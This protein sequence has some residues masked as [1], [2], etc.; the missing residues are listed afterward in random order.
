MR[1]RYG[2]RL[3]IG[4]AQDG[5]TLLH[6]SG[7]LRSRTSI[8]AECRLSEEDVAVPDRLPARLRSILTETKCAGLPTTI[9][10]DDAYCRLWIVTPP[11]NAASLSDCKAAAAVRFQTL[12]GEP[13]TGW[14]LAADWD[15]RRP[16]VACAVP[17]AL[18]QALQQV[19]IEYKL[20]LLDIAPQ[21]IGAWNRWHAGLRP[22][23]WFGVLHEDTLTIGATISGRLQVIRATSVPVALPADSAVDKEWLSGHLSREALRMNLAMPA[24]IQL[25]GPIPGDWTTPGGALNCMRLDARN[26]VSAGVALASTGMQ[27]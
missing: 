10:L 26:T 11:Q 27:Q 3:R 22:N 23:A 5:I 9:M 20:T 17:H 24:D 19:A 25:C 18:L 6:T 7:G 1:R 21:F 15:A 14:E 12:Y 16:F 8:L 4:L 2:D 13:I